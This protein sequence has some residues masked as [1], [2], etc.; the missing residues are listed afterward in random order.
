MR[1]I[2]VIVFILCFI[3]AKPTF[4][5]T[6]LQ[7]QEVSNP[8]SVKGKALLK[9]R[10]MQDE[11]PQAG[12]VAGEHV[13][14]KIKDQKEGFTCVANTQTS[15]ADGYVEGECTATNIG[16]IIVY[17][18]SIDKSDASNEVEISFEDIAP[19]PTPID[20]SKSA[21]MNSQTQQNM[22]RT[23]EQQAGAQSGGLLGG[24]EG[25]SEE[26][27]RDDGLSENIAPTGQVMGDATT[28]GGTQDIDLLVSLIFLAVGLILIIGSAYAVF[29]FIHN[30]KHKTADPPPQST[31]PQTS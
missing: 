9:V 15:T 17:A 21:I 20:A 12:P 30:T 6:R 5:A 18:Q 8:V 10:V 1:F 23:R 25:L 19:S 14:F 27:D 28:S 16:K 13:E 24:G 22:M 31:P 26:K 2:L 3:A 29:T 11:T 7:L 4:A